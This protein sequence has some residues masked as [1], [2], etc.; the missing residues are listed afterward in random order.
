MP[1]SLF[2]MIYS[3]HGLARVFLTLKR[4]WSNHDPIM[5]CHVVIPSYDLSSLKGL[6][7]QQSMGFVTM[8]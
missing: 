6:K 4:A 8:Y 3:I 2:A 7:D 5:S 1:L